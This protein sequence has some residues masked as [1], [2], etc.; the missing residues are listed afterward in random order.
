MIGAYHKWF[1]VLGFLVLKFAHDVHALED[2]AKHHVLAVQVRS[3][4]GRDEKLRAI[5]ARSCVRHGQ[6]A[7]YIMLERMT[8][9]IDKISANRSSLGGKRGGK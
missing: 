3:R 7:R 2:T 4:H 5:R 9:M 1:V 6:Q 8:T